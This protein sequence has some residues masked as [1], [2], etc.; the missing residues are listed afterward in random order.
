MA[1]ILNIE[2]NFETQSSK[3]K[4]KKEKIA[5]KS[6]FYL[7]VKKKTSCVLLSIYIFSHLTHTTK[8]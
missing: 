6:R 5:N 2:F 7:Y 1:K 8:V 3:K 4:K